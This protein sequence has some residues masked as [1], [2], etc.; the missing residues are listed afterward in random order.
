MAKMRRGESKEALGRQRADFRRG[1]P[2]PK[3]HVGDAAVASARGRAA[4]LARV[5]ELRAEMAERQRTAHARE[6]LSVIAT[7][8][9][10]HS[11]RLA[12]ALLGIPFRMVGAL[13]G[14]RPASAHG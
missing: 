3:Q 14:H 2:G 8:I 5:R 13:R 4:E 7:D 12:R 10:V 1:A 9:L 6:P 11:A